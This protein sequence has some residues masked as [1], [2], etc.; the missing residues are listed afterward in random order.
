MFTLNELDMMSIASEITN[1]VIDSRVKF[2]G[3]CS[4]CKGT[5]SSNNGTN[6]GCDSC[7]SSCQNYTS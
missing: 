2:M 1:E 3:G 7:Q 6:G 4:R 5:C